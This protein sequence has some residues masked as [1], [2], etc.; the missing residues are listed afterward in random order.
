MGGCGTDGARQPAIFKL[1]GTAGLSGSLAT[2][3]T[4]GPHSRSLF[5]VGVSAYCKDADPVTQ[6]KK[7]KKIKSRGDS[8]KVLTFFLIN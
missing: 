5:G 6:L 7:K 8:F 2:M 4:P 3:Q 1:Q